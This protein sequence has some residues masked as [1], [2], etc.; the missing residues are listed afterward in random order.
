MTVGA[1][2]NDADYLYDDATRIYDVDGANPAGSIQHIFL[3]DW[4]NDGTFES[5]EAE[6]I[7]DIPQ[8]IRGCAFLVTPNGGG[9]EK[10]QPAQG[11]ITLNNSSGRFDPDNISGALY[12]KLL[13]GRKFR[14]YVK[15]LATK[16][17]WPVMAGIIYDIPAISDSNTVE[18][19]I[20]D[21]MTL[22]D[23]NCTLPTAYMASVRNAITDTLAQSQFTNDF[24]AV[25]DTEDQRITSFDVNKLNALN[26]LQDLAAAS[27]G[28][29]FADNRGAIK[30]YSR[31]HSSMPTIEI[32]QAQCLKTI[33]RSTAWENLRS[34]VQANI[35]KLQKGDEEIAFQ[36]SGPMIIVGQGTNN[37]YT[38]M[39]FNYSGFVDVRLAQA[40]ANSAL[41]DSAVV[42]GPGGHEWGSLISLTVNSINNKQIKLTFHST[43]GPQVYL[44]KLILVGRK[45][46]TRQVT[47][48]YPYTAP[49]TQDGDEAIIFQSGVVDIAGQATEV[50]TGSYSNIVGAHLSSL[51]IKA[52]SGGT[53]MQVYPDSYWAIPVTIIVNDSTYS[54]SIHNIYNFVICVTSL[55]IVGKST[56]DTRTP[57]N[58]D[59]LFVLDSPWLQDINH[60]EAFTKMIYDF[61]R[62]PRRT[63]E[64]TIEQRP[65]LQY[66]FDLL[67]K[68]HFT[69][70]K[71]GIDGV[72]HVGQ[73]THSWNNIP[74]GQSVKTNVVLI[75]RLTDG[76]TIANDPYDPF[77]PWIPVID[78]VIPPVDPPVPPPVE[79]VLEYKG[80]KVSGYWDDICNQ[81][82]RYDQTFLRYL[83][84]G[85]MEIDARPDLLGIDTYFKFVFQID[86]T[87]PTSEVGQVML[88]WEFLSGVCSRSPH[89]VEGYNSALH[90]YE[91]NPQPRWDNT[92]PAT[93][94][95]GLDALLSWFGAENWALTYRWDGD[96]VPLSQTYNDT[97][98]NSGAPDYK[99]TPDLQATE[100]RYLNISI[101][102]GEILSTC[103]WQI[104]KVYIRPPGGDGSTD[105]VIWSY[106]P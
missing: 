33:R 28:Q 62:S 66:S 98:G 68:I 11:T 92:T 46:T 9:F 15:D 38:Y 105:I 48:S 16:T 72:Y 100:S 102:V 23:R 24:G 64:I 17:M 73:I 7:I 99:I 8:I 40:G 101:R 39:T 54:I 79:S 60:G 26:V 84:N 82:N 94:I 93:L 75:P 89:G 87:G 85:V 13:P 57:T 77:L 1:K 67:D 83:D 61:L 41:D 91:I 32:D 29:V 43:I 86:Y 35:T 103:Q 42:Y 95:P 18:L 2:W 30:F 81:D 27:L 58:G 74:T 65:E 59:T 47:A 88:D 20:R 51:I 5:N 37:G 76:S 78:P 70:S 21:S 90:G 49:S 69:S 96:I 104:K 52:N 14:Y 63:I 12:G 22:L 3:V 10:I 4:N 44:T 50:I 53:G 45:I 56:T 106:T 71:L 36:L 19:V 80:N 97:H 6:Y 55:I 34:A 25:I 31:G